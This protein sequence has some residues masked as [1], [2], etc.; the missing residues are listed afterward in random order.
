M[1]R[2]FGFIAA[3]VLAVGT[4]FVA[5]PALANTETLTISQNT[6]GVHQ[7]TI[8]GTVTPNDRVTITVHDA[9][10]PAGQQ[11]IHVNVNSGDTLKKIAKR[12]A[13]RINAAA[14]LSAAG[15]TAESNDSIVTFRSNSPNITTY[16]ATTSGGATETISLSVNTNAKMN[17]VLS[18]SLTPGDE[19][20]IIIHDSGIISGQR[21]ISYVVQTGDTLQSIALSMAADLS[22][23]NALDNLGISA[24]AA[25]NVITIRSY[26]P[27]PTTYTS[28]V[29]VAQTEAISL[30][31]NQNSDYTVI[32]GG[33][34][35]AGDVIA[36]EVVDAALP[37]GR[38]TLGYV[39]QAGDSLNTVASALADSVNA[40]V[41]LATLGVT[42][43]SSGSPF[44][45]LS[46]NSANATTY[47][48]PQTQVVS[49]SNI[50]PSSQGVWPSASQTKICGTATPALAQIMRQTLETIGNLPIDAAARLKHT[51]I[52]AG[53]NVSLSVTDVTAGQLVASAQYQTSGAADSTTTIATTLAQQLSGIADLA[54]VRSGEVI[55][56]SSASGHVLQF[57][58]QSSASVAF[59]LGSSGT[60][61]QA[62]V[63][64]G[65][66]TNI[67]YYFFRSHQEY[68]NSTPAAGGPPEVVQLEED[69]LGYT[70]ANT[71]TGERFTL[72]FQSDPLESNNII[73][74]TTAHE[75]GH[76]VDYI[77]G[78]AF[79]N[80]TVYSASSSGT[81]FQSAL[82]FDLQQMASTPVCAFDAKDPQGIYYSSGTTNPDANGPGL[83]GFFTVVHDHNGNYVCSNNGQGRSLSG[84]SGDVLHVISK[85]FPLIGLQPDDPSKELRQAGEVFSE[86][87][88]V[89][90]GFP[91][92]SDNS[93]NA[94]PGS[95]TLFFE[96]SPQPFACADLDQSTLI[97]YGRQ[98]TP[99]EKAGR[100]YMIPDGTAPTYGPGVSIRRCDGSSLHVPYS[101]GG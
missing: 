64:G 74:H 63:T 86:R 4:L 80:S 9:A 96:S 72:I 13:N 94:I 54:V 14:E 97:T 19:L 35:T 57:S 32:V 50:N 87:F 46:S 70:A 25:G 59:A 51:P 67:T 55:S 90:V 73:A 84:Y 39:A 6:N 77:Y 83:N 10:L 2:P 33:S 3:L 22:S 27:N 11:S 99:A 56:I 68:Y 8:G 101:F 36:F 100:S 43:S 21:R 62:Q 53:E 61:T 40:D 82:S 26:S 38:R 1:K 85:A 75:T 45:A 5:Q 60:T 31:A 34:V 81:P 16:T 88:S 29:I 47:Q 66:R 98:P 93:G 49:C 65:A 79:T 69:A 92:T 7:A 15:I 23:K 48:L 20:R 78:G 37:G 12:L 28:R 41:D 91:D 17:V 44:F 89:S 18:G 71:R 24:S 30:V 52:S 95:D 42:A 58:A 76:Q